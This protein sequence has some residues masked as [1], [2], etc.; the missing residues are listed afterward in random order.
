MPTSVC[1]VMLL[2]VSR[3]HSCCNQQAVTSCAV[4]EVEG[5]RR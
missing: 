3:E 2:N 4:A 1:C 5:W